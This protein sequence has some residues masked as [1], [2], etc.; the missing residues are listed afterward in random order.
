[1]Y[2]SVC[3]DE[4]KSFSLYYCAGVSNGVEFRIKNNFLFLFVCF[5]FKYALKVT[6][7]S[8]QRYET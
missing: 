5:F 8:L 1:M 3:F 4:A 7:L 6:A 2:G